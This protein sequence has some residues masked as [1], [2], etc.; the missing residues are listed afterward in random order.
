[1]ADA[2]RM[3]ALEPTVGMTELVMDITIGYFTAWKATGTRPV[4]Y[5]A[6]VERGA[7]ITMRHAAHAATGGKGKLTKDGYERN[8]MKERKSEKA[9]PPAVAEPAAKARPS[10]T[11][12]FQMD[13][14]K[15]PDLDLAL[16]LPRLAFPQ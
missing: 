9:A 12:V 14:S 16:D 5:L 15:K 10:F 8:Y 3:A 2:V 11:N 6:N 13:W 7:L 1:M 4:G